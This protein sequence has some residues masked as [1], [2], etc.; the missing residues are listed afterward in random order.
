MWVPA[1]NDIALAV[2]EC[3][4]VLNRV[5]GI[6]ESAASPPRL[7]TP[8][9]GLMIVTILAQQMV[10]QNRAKK[11]FF[12]AGVWISHGPLSNAVPSGLA[13]RLGG[14]PVTAAFLEHESSWREH[15]TRELK[16]NSQFRHDVKL[17]EIVGN[18]FLNVALWCDSRELT[19]DAE[20]ICRQVIELAPQYSGGYSVLAQLYLERDRF[21]KAL[22]LAAALMKT[23][24]GRRQ[25]GT[26]TNAITTCQT[27]AQNEK[28][29]EAHCAE[30]PT[31]LA[32]RVELVKAYA[33]RRRSGKLFTVAESLTNE[34]DLSAHQIIEV[35]PPVLRAHD[36]PRAT[37][38]LEHLGK[39]HPE[40]D[41][42]WLWLALVFAVENN[43]DSAVAALANVK[44]W[45]L[46]IDTRARTGA[47]TACC[48][49]H[50]HYPVQLKEQ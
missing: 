34:P 45:N 21:D 43:C 40:V 33:Q 32:A 42:P 50:P 46:D 19:S 9:T 13:Y 23:N 39:A 49:D 22:A 12:T 20:Q 5:E 30:Q 2:E 44:D 27:Y 6:V 31:D 38:F 17:Q 47:Y 14:E 26:F 24:A 7:L 16:G 37:R 15:A 41:A 36:L 3:G 29:L 1:T 4:R 48:R 10:M 35:I 28:R 25:V 8:N 18:L 11:E